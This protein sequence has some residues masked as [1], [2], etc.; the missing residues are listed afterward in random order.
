MVM[1]QH[2]ARIGFFRHLGVTAFSLR[3][4][5]LNSEPQNIEYRTAAWDEPFGHEW[6]D[7]EFFN[8]ELTTEGL[9]VK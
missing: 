4:P 2:G 3:W 8:P 9:R 1:F 7:P 5:E 6:F